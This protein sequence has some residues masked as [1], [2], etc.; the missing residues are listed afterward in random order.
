MGKRL[1]DPLLLAWLALCAVTAVSLV[2]GSGA[3]GSLAGYAVLAIAFAKAAVVMFVFM[4]LRMA[5][6]ALRLAAALWLAAVLGAL[7][8]VHAGWFG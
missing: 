5:P 1:R 2:L 8:A 6:L 3:G 7:L 4:D